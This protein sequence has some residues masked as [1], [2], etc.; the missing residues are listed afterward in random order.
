MSCRSSA[1]PVFMLLVVPWMMWLLVLRHWSWQRLWLRWV[2]LKGGV[3]VGGGPRRPKVAHCVRVKTAG[4]RSFRST[5][6]AGL[7]SSV[8]GTLEHGWPLHWWAFERRRQFH[9][10]WVAWMCLHAAVT[11]EPRTTSPLQLRDG[12]MSHFVQRLV[13]QTIPEQKS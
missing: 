5:P 1:E 13:K 3:Y 2:R 7:H 12:F 4:G 11:R 9:G 8:R 6:W 10:V